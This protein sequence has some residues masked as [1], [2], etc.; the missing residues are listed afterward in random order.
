MG[1]VR[2]GWDFDPVRGTASRDTRMSCSREYGG[3]WRGEPFP[4]RGS[5]KR[6]RPFPDDEP[7]VCPSCTVSVCLLDLH[8]VDKHILYI[9]KH[10]MQE[11]CRPPAT[12]HVCIIIQL[13]DS[14]AFE[15]RDG[16]VERGSGAGRR[17]DGRE[18]E[19]GRWGTL[20]AQETSRLPWG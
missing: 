16:H 4:K 18:A 12:E 20:R 15:M 6:C 3:Q 13:R 7:S 9:A 19:P 8:P 5:R 10:S 2:P 17:S 1:G 14:S 11:D